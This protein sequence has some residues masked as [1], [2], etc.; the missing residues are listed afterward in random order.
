MHHFGLSGIAEQRLVFV[1]GL[2]TQQT[3]F[4]TGV[5]GQATRNFDTLF[6]PDGDHVTA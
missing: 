5:I 6:I 3:G 1:R 2:A 4:G